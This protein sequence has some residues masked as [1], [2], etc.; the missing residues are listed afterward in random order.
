MVSGI[1]KLLVIVLVAYAAFTAMVYYS[2]ASLI[3]Y[4][5][6]PSRSIVATPAD[7][8]LA[9]DEVNFST[10]DEIELHGWFV[11]ANGAVGTL[12]FFHGNAGNISHRLE[13]I[14]LFNAIG[15]NVFIFDYR[16][17]G[18]SE[19]KPSESGTYRDADAA[20]EYLSKT[21]GINGREIILFGRSLGA[22][23]A[24]YLAGQQCS[25][26]LIV[27]SGF[28]SVP[29][30]AK[31]LYPFLPVEWLSRFRY[32]TASFVSNLNCPLLVVHSKQD[33]IVPY[34]EGRL[35]FEAAQGKKSFLDILGGHNDGFLVSGPSYINGVKDFID[36]ALQSARVDSA[37]NQ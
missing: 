37:T 7:R 2:Q 8:G 21:R 18:Q 26:G 6:F 20:F 15:L 1:L 22:P 36:S 34:E 25:A 4:P 9:F 29:S 3:Y 11:P 27:E 32:H 16:G 28:S 12:L 24:A 33:E 13:S 10:A 17:Y 30:M 5:D 23:I 19:G 35:I 14:Q 31:R